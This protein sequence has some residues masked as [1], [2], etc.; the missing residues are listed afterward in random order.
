M[1]LYK[2]VKIHFTINSSF[3]TCDV[4]KNQWMD[5]NTPKWCKLLHPN[6]AHLEHVAATWVFASIKSRVLRINFLS[7]AREA[8]VTRNAMGT[9]RER[10]KDARGFPVSRKSTSGPNRALTAEGLWYF[11]EVDDR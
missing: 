3:L 11:A 6:L 8:A 9:K 5:I 4:D 1:L 2:F 7:V 10:K